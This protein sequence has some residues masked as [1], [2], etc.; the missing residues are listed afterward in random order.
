MTID[1]NFV[2]RSTQEKKLYGFQRD[3]ATN[4]LD[5]RVIQLR[6]GDNTYVTYSEDVEV[7][8]TASSRYVYLFDR[9][10]KTFTVYTSNPIKTTQGNQMIYNLQYV[11]RY[12]FDTSLQIIDVAMPD[13][14]NAKP[15]LYVMTAEGIYESNISETMSLYENK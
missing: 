4:K 15:I 6:G 8:A 14:N 1:G 3:A 2:S 10:N 12:A 13:I 9:K 5:S 11:M 7:L